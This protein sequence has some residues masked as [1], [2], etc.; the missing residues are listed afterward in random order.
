MR[1]LYPHRRMLRARSCNMAALH[2]SQS[3]FAGRSVVAITRSAPRPVAQARSGVVVRAE[4]AFGER[5]HW[6]PGA[7]ASAPHTSAHPPD[8]SAQCR[9]HA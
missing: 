4:G 6:F 3:A 2:C 7:P 1:D 5:G 8:T 9:D